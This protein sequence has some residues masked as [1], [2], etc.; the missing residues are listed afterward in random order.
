MGKGEESNGTKANE[1]TYLV[2]TSTE[3]SKMLEAALL[4]M[5]GIISGACTDGGAESSSEWKDSVKDATRN[6]V[7]AIQNAP[8]PPTPPDDGIVELLLQWLQPIRQMLH[9][10]SSDGI[11]D[12]HHQRLMTLQ[13]RH[14]TQN[15]AKIIPRTIIEESAWILRVILTKLALSAG[16]RVACVRLAS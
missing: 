2:K 16:L 14:R 6:L 9:R 3:A 13:E 12:G 15:K 5:D 10:L 4:Q 11:I 7:S 1:S 8:N